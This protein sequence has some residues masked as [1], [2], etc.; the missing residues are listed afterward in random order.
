MRGDD[1]YFLELARGGVARA[2]VV[3]STRL[4]G[5]ADARGGQDAARPGV[6]TV[7]YAFTVF[8]VSSYDV[9]I[10]GTRSS[11]CATL[12]PRNRRPSPLFAVGL[13]RPGNQHVQESA[14]GH[15]FD[16][17]VHVP[18]I[19]VPRRIV[20]RILGHDILRATNFSCGPDR[21]VPS[22]G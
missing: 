16:A 18:A 7:R 10:V 2:R 17:L 5:G 9:V 21:F 14:A 3:M 6:L 11:V 22:V 19:G 15:V 12:P 4:I 8:R 1:A 13:G 20:A